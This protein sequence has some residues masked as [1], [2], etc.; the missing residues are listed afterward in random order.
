MKGGKTREKT[1]TVY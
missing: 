1:V